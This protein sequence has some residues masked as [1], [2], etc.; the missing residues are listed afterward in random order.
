MTLRIRSL[1]QE[2]LG[3][4]DRILRL[5]FDTFLGLKGTHSNF[6][7]R[8]LV[9]TRWRTDP[10][11]A[12]AAELDGRLVG[13]NFTTCWG[14]V[15]FFGPLSVHP[16]LW[17]QGIAQRLLASAMTQFAKWQSRHVGLFTFANS[18]GH[19]AL[20]QRFDFWPRFVTAIM[21]KVPAKS[22]NTSCLLF[23]EATKEERQKLISECVGLTDGI[24]PGLD[25]SRE[26]RAVQAQNL[27][28]TLLVVRDSKI[29]A[30]AVCH[31][32][33]GTEAGSGNCYVKFGAARPGSQASRDFVQLLEAC[34]SLAS[35][36]Q[37]RTIR[38]GVNLGRIESYKLLLEHGFRTEM[39]GIA[40]QHANDE[41][42]NR[43]GIYVL[44]DWR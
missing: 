23:S 20:Y 26:I 42:Y 8:D 40:M 24:Y 38:A 32:G 18:P 22:T 1:E 37:L 41:G 33:S 28:D 15:S 44:D 21:S 31:I 7:D 14:T 19:A 35:A 12:F 43:P 17:N 11:G 30:F 25:V 27:G 36:R 34:E 3:E 5:A 16:E 9:R 39:H 6:G 2:D 4:A 10:K 13:S 29:A